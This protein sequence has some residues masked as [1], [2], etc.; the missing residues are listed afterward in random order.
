MTSLK[1]NFYILW[2]SISKKNQFT[3]YLICFLTI[4]LSIF[5]AATLGSLVPFLTAITSPELILQNEYFKIIL[6]PLGITNTD[7]IAITST[8]LFITVT[9]IT[10]IFRFA[11]LRLQYIFSHKSANDLSNKIFDNMTNRE[12]SDVSK[13]NSSDIISTLTQKMQQFINSTLLPLLMLMSSLM[14]FLVLITGLLIIDWKLTIGLGLILVTTYILGFLFVKDRIARNSRIISF[15][16]D[17]LVKA[18]QET[19]GGI[20]EI[21]LGNHKKA[22]KERF[23]KSDILVRTAQASTLFFAASPKMLI[24]VVVF[25]SV[26]IVAYI[27]FTESGS[28]V[29]SIP[30]LGAIAYAA[31]RMLPII[32]LVYANIISIRGSRD[33]V[34]D[35]CYLLPNIKTYQ[36]EDYQNILIDNNKTEFNSNYFNEFIV[37]NDIS[38]K[39]SNDDD[40]AI[41]N[42]S[43]EIKPGDRI[44]IFG[45]TGSG[46]STLL[47]IIMGLIEPSSGEILCDSIPRKDIEDENWYRIFSHVPQSIYLADTSIMNNIG[48]LGDNDSIDR[49][50][51]IEASKLAHILEDID[52]F[53]DG[54]ETIVGERGIRLSGGQLQR[55]GIARALYEPS[56]ILVLDEATSAIDPT[57]EKR[58]E[59]SLNGLQRDIA[60]IKVAHR[61]STLEEC[62]IVYEISDGRIVRVGK[63]SDLFKN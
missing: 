35:L 17:L 46:K 41:K 40:F 32:Q 4:V 50:R 57:L 51:A 9:I 37:L 29:M 31:Q 38:F 45:K 59:A 34:Q 22:V 63:Y 23:H 47:D 62:D 13:I 30:T 53:K 28:V 20:R 60:V 56:K 7:Q 6:E 14:V 2:K 42:I 24:E 16:Y 15:E 1:S 33:I 27:A 44:G 55:L 10:G 19:F 18:I 25:V 3:F 12:Y 5:E 48:G 58:I 26:A 39:Y 11:L 21:I 43:L 54:F 61:I 36:E 52:T 8:I 49:N